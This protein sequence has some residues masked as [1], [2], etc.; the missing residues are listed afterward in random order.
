[1]GRTN[2]SHKRRNENAKVKRAR[3]EI[4]ELAM[5][6]KTLGIMD[7]E[8]PETVEQLAEVATIKSAKEIKQEKKSKEEEQLEFEL[9]EE[10]HQGDKITIVNEKTGK[11]HVYNTKTLKDQHGSYPGWY[12]PRK[13]AKRI[14][15]KD[16]A[17]RL[18]FKQHWTVT[19]VPL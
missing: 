2:K 8:D 14:R 15:K 4:K 5:L 1:M 18:R 17:R 16:H 19:N 13:T 10:R 3:Y 7:T 6:K 12:K 9:K 11:T